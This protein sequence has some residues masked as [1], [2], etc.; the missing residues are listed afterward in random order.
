MRLPALDAENLHPSRS[1][2]GEVFASANIERAIRRVER[3]GGAPG[4]D[5]VSTTQLRSHWRIHWPAI[6]ATLDAG[7]YWPAPVRRVEIPKPGGGVRALG[8]PTVQDRVIQQAILQVLSPIFD[9]HFHGSSFGFRPNRSAHMA[10]NQARRFVEDGTN[11]V[12]DLDLEEFFDRINHDK[13]MARVARKV[14]DKQ[15]LRLIRA[16]LNA[17]VMNA[18]V[19]VR[20]EEGTPQ[21]GPLSPLLANIMLDDLDKELEKRGHR[22]VRYADDLTI[23]VASERAGQRVFESISGFVESKLKLRVNRNKSK[24]APATRAHLLGFGLLKRKGRVD[25]RI[26]PKAKKKAKDRIRRLTA[27]TWS[28]PMHRRIAAINIYVR[29]W[30]GYFGLSDTPSIFE[31]FDE[32]LHRRLRQVRWKE[33]KR[34]RT[35]A[36]NLQAL[37]IPR[38]K[39]F[40]WAYTRKGSWR[41]AGSAPL[42]RALPAP[43]WQSLGLVG[44]TASYRRVRE[45]LRTAGCG[46]ACPVV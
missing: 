27:R 22:F 6:K 18:G 12:V 13:L 7:T 1:L 28:V 39:A 2:W 9:P 17:G 30:T 16:L 21:G 40:Q 43:Y 26:D 15:V 31:E 3:N 46:P 5:G 35:K 37:G 36:R 23:Y 33:W 34:P 38:R 42:Q 29:G 25:V 41:L 14:K 4:I 32:W 10:V 8:V 11:W 20:T 44:F 45:S 24:V 19:C